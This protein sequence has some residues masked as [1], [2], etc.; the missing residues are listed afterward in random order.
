MRSYK[1]PLR[2]FKVVCGGETP[3]AR[4]ERVQTEIMDRETAKMNAE[5]FADPIILSGTPEQQ[6]KE[7]LFAVGT[8]EKDLAFYR[9]HTQQLERKIKQLEA[10][11]KNT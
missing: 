2:S 6:V 5:R 9:K 4:H 3:E 8:Y 1:Y 10:Q 11:I 7:L